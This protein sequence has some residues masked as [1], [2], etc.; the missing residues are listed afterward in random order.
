M[1]TTVISFSCDTEGC[2]SKFE[3]Q[4]TLGPGF[5]GLPKGWASLNWLMEGKANASDPSSRFRRALKKVRHH[6]PPEMAE[7]Q[8][9]GV[10]LF[11]NDDVAPR[12]ISCSAIICDKCLD[13]L[14]LGDFNARGGHMLG[15]V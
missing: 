13:K 3:E 6:L 9:A 7:F 2:D 1:M 14:N 15:R 8:A 11:L 10:D 5:A 12:P 4:D